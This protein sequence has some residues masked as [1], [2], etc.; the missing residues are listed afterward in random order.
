MEL[1]KNVCSNTFGIENV[2]SLIFDE[3]EFKTDNIRFN[4]VVFSCGVETI[5]K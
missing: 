2:L 4:C 1:K 3:S 5:L